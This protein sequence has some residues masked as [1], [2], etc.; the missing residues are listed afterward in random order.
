MTSI[1]RVSSSIPLATGNKVQPVES[2]G[3]T[4][5]ATEKA[6]NILNSHDTLGINKAVSGELDLNTEQF[7]AI[8]GIKK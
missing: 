8:M 4:A 6:E 7:L 5:S 1:G 2:A 3:N